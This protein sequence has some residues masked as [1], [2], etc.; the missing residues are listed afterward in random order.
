MDKIGTTESVWASRS[1]DT[2]KDLLDQLKYLVIVLE[3]QLD[4]TNFEEDYKQTA[5]EIDKLLEV[6]KVQMDNGLLVTK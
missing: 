5:M 3:H 4:N 1:D 2:N 6:V